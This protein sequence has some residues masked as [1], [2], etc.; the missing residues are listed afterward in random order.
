MNNDLLKIF[1]NLENPT[2]PENLNKHSRVMLIDGMNL[3]LR[4]FAIINYVNN[5]GSHIG[6]LSGF[7]RSLG[8]L[9]RNNNPTSVY[10]VFGGIGSS[11]NRR[12]LVPE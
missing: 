10:V 8:Y 7:I 5:D 6:G 9:I 4:N 11:V 1:N 12:N 3:F 2:P